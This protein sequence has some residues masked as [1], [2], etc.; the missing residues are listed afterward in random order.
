M[1]SQG[2]AY[3]RFRRAL[4]T[5]N[6][7]IAESAARELRQLS[8]ADALALCLLYRGDSDRYERAAARWL[9]RCLEERPSMR[10]DHLELLATC[11]RGLAGPSPDRAGAA[12]A[13]VFE[14]D[15]RADLAAVVRD[16]RAA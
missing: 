16:P 8:L 5:G 9:A 7:G 3:A 15:G 2:H 10:L 11:L 12:L 4:A 6:P 14:R 13:S 1:T